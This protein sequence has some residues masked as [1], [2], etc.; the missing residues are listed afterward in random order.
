[1]LSVA[2]SKNADYYA[3]LAREDYY[4]GGQE[5]PGQY[6]GA[7][8]ARLG[9]VGQVQNGD[10]ARL[11]AGFDPRTNQKIASNAGRETHKSGWDFTF[12]S[13]KSVSAVWAVA[14]QETK[15]AISAAQEKAVQKAMQYF[16]ENAAHTRHGHGGHTHHSAKESAIIAS[17]EHSANR[18]GEPQ[19][20]THCLLINGT[21]EGRALDIDLRAKMAAG[22]LYRV[23]LA[24]QMQELGFSITQT[25]KEF[26]VDGVKSEL[27]ESWSS[28]RAE[29]VK[30]LS[31]CLSRMKKYFYIS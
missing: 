3:S 31:P 25:A 15:N 16:C 21:P 24:Q 23:E 4:Q 6:L 20:H 2:T 18:L 5:P 30:T 28:R 1:M 14:G 26:Q 9:L 19:L 12:S 27:C 8:A 11:F 7:G 10:L 13:P 22:A 17:F 29:I